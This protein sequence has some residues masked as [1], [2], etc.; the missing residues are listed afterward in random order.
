MPRRKPPQDPPR[1]LPSHVSPFRSLPHNVEAE[2]AV[3]CEC[4]L[5]GTKIDRVS[6]EL[7]PDDFF[8]DRH[9]LIYRAALE[10]R[11]AGHGVDVVTV[12]A[13]LQDAETLASAGGP[14]YLGKLIGET[15]ATVHLE[16]H[17]GIVRGLARRRRLILA[18]QRRADEGYEAVPVDWEAAAVQEVVDAAGLSADP[19]GAV[20]AAW[21]PL[22]LELV[23]T[24]PA[25]RRWLLRH[26]TRDGVDAPPDQGDGL[27]PLGK[28]GALVAE[29]GA[30]KT[31]ALMQ[32]AI[33]IATGVRWLGHFHVSHEARSGRV[34][35]ALAEEDL[36][37]VHRRLFGAADALRLDLPDRRLIA[38]RVVVLPL[39]G[40]PVSLIAYA[41][42]GVTLTDSPELRTI[43]QRLRDDAHRTE[44][45]WSL[46]VLD[47][48]ARWA[49]PD[50]ESDNAAATR[51]VQAVEGL[52]DAPGNPTVLVAHHS[53]KIAR[54]QGKVDARGVTGITDGFRWVATLRN[55]RG[56]VM[57][58][59]SK[60]NYS[61]PMPEELRLSRQRGGLLRVPSAEEELER[62]HRDAERAEER[63]AARVE[64][65]ERRIASAER[66]IL[67][68]VSESNDRHGGPHIRSR[69]DLVALV[70][71]TQSEKQA[72]VTRLIESGRL[73]KGE[74]GY[75]VAASGAASTRAPREGVSSHGSE[76][77]DLHQEEAGQGALY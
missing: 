63:A 19:R 75:E 27:L 46:V 60:S 57:F 14:G 29:G 23:T 74:Q 51:F 6:G 9:R 65:E 43:R 69:R 38:E 59:Q 58:G 41:D 49:G 35:L 68:A 31:H 8:V 1:E 71:G 64:A 32:L 34:L 36:E 56:E 44:C 2:Q 42:D 11:T 28:A 25:P 73:A 18:M 55:A 26:P 62:E 5:D 52:V 22:P 66:S 45:G 77:G 47:P 53:S 17:A 13:R 4:L 70:K 15:P 10:L 24:P 40:R 54:Q 30:G 72:A 39:A 76:Q 48:L 12:G 21:K 7:E 3:L 33:S 61:I 50:V 16:A 20:A 37:E 67:Q